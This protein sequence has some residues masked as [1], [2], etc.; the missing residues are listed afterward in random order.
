M[1]YSISPSLLFEKHIETEILE[2]RKFIGSDIAN[3]RSELIALQFFVT[4]DALQ[5]MPLVDLGLVDSG[6]KVSACA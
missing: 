2:K 5:W 1:N 4:C 6:S 3:I